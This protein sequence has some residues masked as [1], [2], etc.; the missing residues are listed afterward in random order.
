MYKCCNFI[1]VILYVNKIKFID[2]WVNFYFESYLYTSFIRTAR[3][4]VVASGAFCVTGSPSVNLK[5]TRDHVTPKIIVTY[6]LIF[7]LF[8][9]LQ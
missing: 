8:H 7:F 4:S 3:L 5:I 6:G 1:N 2:Y 9:N